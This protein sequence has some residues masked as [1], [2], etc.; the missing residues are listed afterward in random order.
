VARSAAE[1]TPD[2]FE[3]VTLETFCFVAQIDR[4]NRLDTYLQGRLKAMSRSRV[5]KLIQWGWIQVNGRTPK[6]SST[7][8]PGDRVDVTLP[9]QASRDIEPEPIPLDILYEDDHL[10]VVNKPTGIIVHPAR[11]VHTG[12]LLNALAYH[13]QARN[14]EAALSGVGAGDARPGVVHRLDKNTTGCILFAKHDDTH[15]AVARQFE[16]RTCLKAYLALV[17]GNFEPGAESGAIDQPIGRH[18]TIHE[19]YS[20]RRDHAAKSAVTLYRVRE[21]YEG[22]SLV[23]LELKT[24]RTHQIRVH[25]TWLGHPIVGDLTYGGEAIGPAEIDDPPEAAGARPLLSYARTKNQGLQ[26]AQRAADRQDL[27]LATPALHA[28]MLRIRHPARDEQ[29]TFT[30]PLPP[31]F[32]NVVKALRQRPRPDAPH[33]HRGAWIDLDRAAPV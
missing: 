8:R 22:Y 26:E 30:A 2:D 7:L 14:A 19:A 13:L 18:P 12:T 31:D 6:P 21:Q 15:W 1:L 33:L 32:M 24:G 28:A 23:E 20:V 17:H 16:N 10:L 3:D 9:P 25:L 27:M 5:Q 11:G 4:K 29:I